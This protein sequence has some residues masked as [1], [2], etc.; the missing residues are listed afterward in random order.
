MS[1]RKKWVALVL[2]NI[3]DARPAWDGAVPGCSDRCP[4]YDGKRCELT[5]NR[6]YGVCAPA[7]EAMGA[8]LDDP[9]KLEAVQ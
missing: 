2:H 6:P 1:D 7:V 5:G 8:I 3:D 9:T 4:H